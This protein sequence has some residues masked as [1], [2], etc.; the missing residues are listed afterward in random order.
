MFIRYYSGM[1]IDWTKIRATVGRTLGRH[2]CEPGWRLA[3]DWWRS[4][5]DFDLWLVYGGRGVMH[6]DN[7]TVILRPGVCFWARPGHRYEATHDPKNRLRVN[8]VHFSLIDQRGRALPYDTS[9]PPEV[10]EIT[11]L[12]YAVSVTGRIVDLIHGPA[13]GRERHKNRGIAD[14]LLTALL[15]DLDAASSASTAQPLG[16]TP[17]HYHQLVADL[18]SRINE[19]PADAP[20]VAGMARRAGYSADHFARIFKSVVGQSPQEY[21]VQARINRARALLTESGLSIGQI[22]D[23]LGYDDI[24]FFSRQFKSRTGQSPSRYRKAVR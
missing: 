8:S 2:Y 22:A 12:D 18:V 5:R 7:A 6:L 9:V 4:L 19:S 15:M 21:I 17:R 16:G 11:N 13:L 3:E 1:K 10:H 24:Y 20:T 14:Q 23:M